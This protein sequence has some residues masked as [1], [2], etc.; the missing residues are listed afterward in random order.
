M[1][2]VAIAESTPGPVAV[3]AATYVGYKRVG[4]IGAVVSTV[5]VCVPSFAIIFAISLFFNS[6]LEISVIAA[7]FRGIRVGVVFLII[8]AGLKLLKNL[9]KTVF[10][11]IVL[12]STLAC[13]VFFSLFAIDF[14]AVFYILISATLGICVYLI[15]FLRKRRQTGR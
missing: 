11:F 7:A 12:F 13:T 1:D 2:M 6:F 14:T 15:G 9:P 4:I 5:A 10:N 3:N 8:T